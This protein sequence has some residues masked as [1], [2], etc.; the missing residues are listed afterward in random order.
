MAAIV[1]ISSLSSVTVAAVTTEIKPYTLQYAVNQALELDPWLTANNLREQSA[2]HLSEGA[3]SLPDP[4]FN[5]G[6]KNL[7]TD[8][9]DF[10]QEGMTQFSIGMSQM[11]PRGDTL[12]LKGLKYQQKANQQPYLRQERQ[13]AVKLKVTELWLTALQA[14]MSIDLI[15]QNRSL[16][17]QLSDIATSSYS[18]AFGRARQQD[19]VRAELELTSLEDRL[20]QLY[21][22][23]EIALQKLHPWLIP[24]GEH[25]TNRITVKSQLP[26]LKLKAD[27]NATNPKL[28]QHL[29]KNPRVLVIDQGIAMASTDI[30][31]A[32]QKFKPEW[33]LNANYGFRADTPTGA[34][35]ADLFSL[36]VSVDLPVFSTKKQ[37]SAVKAASSEKEALKTDRLLLLRNLQ[38]Q[39]NSSKAKLDR[40]DN[41]YQLYQ[42]QL[43]PGLAETAET[44]INGYTVDDGTF[45]E[46]VRAR[47][48]ELNSRLAALNI[49]VQR[50]KTIAAINYVLTQAGNAGVTEQ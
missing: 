28:I 26:N 37:D 3:T 44:A 48:S 33:M 32:E 2:L 42:E 18:S 19:L 35:R 38:A 15:N 17:E 11:F 10:D 22:Q 7:P 8:T 34:D 24:A 13:A 47:I 4:K 20:T 9:F 6:I 41:R 45:A 5:M 25:R 36:V 1:F 27:Y 30:Q 50:Q 39:Y 14:Q 43:L 31:L 12:A 23:K 49:N 16:F 46:V 21:Q 29:T 40:L